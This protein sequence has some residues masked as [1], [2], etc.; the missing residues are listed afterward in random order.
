[1]ARYGIAV[2]ITKCTGCHNCFIACKDE[3]AGNDYLPYTAAQPREGQDW[4]RLQEVEQ[5]TGSKVKVDYI[6]ILCQHC[7]DAPCIKN[8]PEGT[9]YRRDDGIVLIDVEKAKGHKEIVRTCPYRAIFWNEESQLPQKCTLCAHMID[10]GE[11]TT[12]CVESC[13]ND[14]LVF[15][16]LDDKNSKISKLLAEKADLVEDFK[17]ELECDPSVKYIDL[18][19]YF[20]AGEVLL[21]DKPNECLKGAKVTLKSADD[22]KVVA[23]TTT[24]F[25][26]D[27]E[28]KRLERE[29]EYVVVAEYDGY[30]KAEITVRMN[31][32]KNLGVI[33]LEK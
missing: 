4:I 26:G 15:G 1:M 28:F 22:S 11:M 18:P 14:A 12:R 5:G 33:M 9:I 7:G 21:T 2:D 17:P 8:S 24:D 20:I 31:A 13:P 27:F 30:K 19:K 3:H 25:F 32:S 29:K 16:D 6:P 23:E 10:N